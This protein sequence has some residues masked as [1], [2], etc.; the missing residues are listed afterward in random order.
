MASQSGGSGK[1]A[2]SAAASGP[3][4]VSLFLLQRNSSLR[5]CVP[6]IG[7]DDDWLW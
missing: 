6:R 2:A 3:H 5:A 1:R 4:R 7:G